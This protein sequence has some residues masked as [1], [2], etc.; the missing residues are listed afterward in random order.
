MNG[1]AKIRVLIVDDHDMVR[2]GLTVLL[3]SFAQMEVV[4]QLGDARMLLAL[5]AAVQPDVIL[6]DVLMP[7]ISGVEATKQIHDKYPFIQIVALSSTSDESQ[8]TDM[9]KAGALSYILKSGSIDDVVNAVIA[10]HRGDPTLATEATNVL[11]SGIIRP[12]K[13][14][15]NLSKQ[16]LRVLA[17]VVEGL[18]N[19]EIAD[20][21]VVSQ[22][23]V[24]AHVGNILTKLDTRSRTKAIAIAIR[25]H[26]LEGAAHK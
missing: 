25:T 13:V 1:Q 4:G 24:K 10:A 6:M 23:T 16:E 7:H 18:N 5:C 15:F 21:L 20:R 12:N 9:L 26:I 2:H 22:S 19:R 14:G 8:I 11:L 17:F 3:Q